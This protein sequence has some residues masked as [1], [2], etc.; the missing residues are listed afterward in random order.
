MVKG[1]RAERKQRGEAL[2]KLEERV[3]AY[4]VLKQDEEWK[5]MN[6][7]LCPHCGRTIE[8]IEGCNQMRCGYDVHGG[9]RY[10][11][12][13]RSFDW[14]SAEPYQAAPRVK[15][16][17]NERTGNWTQFVIHP[18]VRCDVCSRD[19]FGPRLRCI[20]CESFT[21][22]TTCESHLDGHDLTHVF[23]ASS[24]SEF[25]WGTFV[26]G[27]L[28]GMQVR[29]S[30]SA[31]GVLPPKW[32]GKQLEGSLGIID[33]EVDHLSAC[34][35]FGANGRGRDPVKTYYKLRIKGQLGS[36]PEVPVENLV[37]L[38][39]SRVQAAKFLEGRFHAGGDDPQLLEPWMKLGPAISGS[40]PS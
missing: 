6:C 33:S 3:R 26:P 16:Q 29:I 18:G 1:A 39:K 27:L 19:V 25:D 21:V 24:H 31:F 17:M 30:R 2:K 14:A 40:S 13:G 7:R 35:G 36:Y 34:A 9:G 12:C 23:E 20:H 22:C 15:L 10:G 28:P 32:F 37:P 11:G 8:K 38:F 5:S 4:T